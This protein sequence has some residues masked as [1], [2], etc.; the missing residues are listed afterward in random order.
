MVPKGACLSEITAEIKFELGTTRLPADR[1][2]NYPTSAL[3]NVCRLYEKQSGNLDVIS[4]TFLLNKL[5]RFVAIC[6]A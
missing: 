5:D 4:T 1:L 2:H 6:R 3:K